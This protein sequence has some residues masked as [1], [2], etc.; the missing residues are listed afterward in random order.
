MLE[1][2]LAELAQGCDA[3]ISAAAVADYTLDANAEKIKSGQDLLLHLK[4]TRKIIKTVREAYPD[5]KIVGFKA[6]TNA[7]D[8]ELLAR[9][10]ESLRGAKLDLVVANDVAR[11]GMGTDDNRVLIVDR[12]GGHREAAGKK[13]L[14][15]KS[16]IDALTEVL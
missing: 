11:G 4:P 3:L 9:A 7:S 1:A 15:A 14:I 6:E 2:V 10:E 8:E 16:I 5:L 12:S 13:S